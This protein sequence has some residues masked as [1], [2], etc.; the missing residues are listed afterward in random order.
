MKGQVLD[1]SIQSNSGVIS[2]DDGKRY[3][4]SGEDWRDAGMPTPGMRVDFDVERSAARN[5]YSEERLSGGVRFG[6]NSGTTTQAQAFP[7]STG[8]MAMPAWGDLVVP[9]LGVLVL[10]AS[11]MLATSH[12]P[13]AYSIVL[14]LLGLAA[15][16]TYFLPPAVQV[17]ARIAIAALGLITLLIMFKSISF[18]MALLPFLTIGALQ[19]PRRHTLRMPLHTIRWLQALQSGQNI[20]ETLTLQPETAGVS[21]PAVQPNP[22]VQPGQ[23]APAGGIADT[24]ARIQGRASRGSGLQYVGRIGAAIMGVIVLLSFL[25]PWISFSASAGPLGSLVGIGGYE[26][27]FSGLD[28]VRGAAEIAGY[29]DDFAGLYIVPVVAAVIALLAV[30]GIASVALPRAVPVIAGIAGIVVMALLFIGYNVAL[31]QIM[32][33]EFGE[34]MDYASMAG[35]EAGVSLGIGFWA[36]T[37]AFLFMAIL[38]LAPR[39]RK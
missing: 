15:I 7:G 39:S 6:L 33:S 19:I 37:L 8:G 18:W 34:Y 4:F 20:A 2:G 36:S 17:E 26:E 1:V 10:I 30:L 38:Q 9:A 13:L 27:S 28:L 29:D 23:P 3:P 24:T 35:A 5:V 32:S 12:W 25:L 11:L 31:Y 14:G 16:G 22:A 21:Y